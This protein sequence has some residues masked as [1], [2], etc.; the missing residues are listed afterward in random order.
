MQKYMWEPL[1]ITN[2][3]FH[4][5]QRPDMLTRLSAMTERGG[6]STL[7]GTASDPL[8]PLGWTP[9][10]WLDGMADDCGG[11]GGYGSAVDYQKILDSITAGDNKLL[12]SEMLDELFKPQLGDVPQAQLEE[13]LAIKEIYSGI[14]PSL[15]IGLK[16]GYALGGMVVLEDIEGR[17]RKG[18]MHWA[19]LPNMYWWADRVGGVSGVY[20]TQLIPSTD[21][22]STEMF[23]KF[24]QT[25]YER[26]KVVRE[27]NAS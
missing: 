15:P 12:G 24:E 27:G 21:L 19:G 17:R 20:A 26:V 1:G 22:K 2:M 25:I 11:A 23:R 5:Q 6:G 8:G 9:E 16:F 13:S 4:L 10:I 14:A 7:F 3:A 18:S